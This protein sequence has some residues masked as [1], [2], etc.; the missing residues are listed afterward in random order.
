VRGGELLDAPDAGRIF[1]GGPADFF[2]VH[3]DPLT[4]PT[5]LW[6]VWRVAWLTVPRTG[7]WARGAG[8][9]ASTPPSMARH[10]PGS[11][12][13]GRGARSGQWSRGSAAWRRHQWDISPSNCTGGAG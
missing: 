13:R 6:R 12:D 1:E 9:G 2:L 5:A 4:D 7:P 8:R 11:V 10:N 3:G